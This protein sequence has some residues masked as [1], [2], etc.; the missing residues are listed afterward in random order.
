MDTTSESPSV[1]RRHH[2][3]VAFSSSATLQAIRR[4]P[5]PVRTRNISVGGISVLASH[6]LAVDTACKIHVA[7]PARNGDV[8]AVELLAR[9]VSS[10]FNRIEGG[11]MLGFQFVNLSASVAAT[12]ARF[13]QSR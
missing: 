13:M 10:N 9:V 7:I 12:I 5:I 8:V 2:Q 3:R 6:E 1:E 4:E 11:F